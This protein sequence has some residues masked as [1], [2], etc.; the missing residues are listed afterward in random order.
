MKNLQEQRHKL[1]GLIN[2]QIDPTSSLSINCHNC[3]HCKRSSFSVEYD[4]CMKTGGSYCESVHK[5]PSIYGHLCN[6]YSSW[7]PRKNTIEFK[8]PFAIQAIL[9]GVSML[10]ISYIFGH[11]T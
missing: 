3:D 10:G 11:L 8:I 5:Y 7:T 9:F 6:N 4:R 1:E 2:N